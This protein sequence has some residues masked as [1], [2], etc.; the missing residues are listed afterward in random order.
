MRFATL[1]LLQTSF[2]QAHAT[3][4]SMDELADKLLEKLVDKLFGMPMSQSATRM[5]AA[6]ALPRP[7]VH[8]SAMRGNYLQQMASASASPLA[9]YSRSQAQSLS[10]I[11]APTCSSVSCMQDTLKSHG[12]GSSPMQKLALTALAAT[13][14]VSMAAQIKEDFARLDDKTKASVVKAESAVLEKMAGV[15]APMNFWDPWG[16]T[17][18]AEDAEILFYR[19]IELKH[20]RMAMLACLGVIAGEKFSPLFGGPADVPASFSVQ[21]TTNVLFWPAVLIAVSTLETNTVLKFGSIDRFSAEAK[22][23]GWTLTGGRVPGDF[24]WDPLNL[25]PKDPVKLLDL[26]NKELNNGRLAMFAAAGMVAQELLTG[27]K[28]F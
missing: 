25:K 14:D 1:L 16:F 19:E 15:T 7:Q 3:Q 13:R 5:G 2:A 17:T 26:Q 12:I 10:A 22:K 24:G 20:G 28:L 21:E 9:S 6:L 11:E 8:A 18:K 4:D 27:K 23:N